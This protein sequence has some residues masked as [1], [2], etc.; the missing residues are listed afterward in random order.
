[1]RA[2]VSRP[3]CARGSTQSI[4]DRYRAGTTSRIRLN[5]SSSSIC[6]L[7][8]V[9]FNIE[10]SVTSAHSRLALVMSCATADQ[11]ESTTESAGGSQ[12]NCRQCRQTSG[13]SSACQTD[14]RSSGDLNRPEFGR[15]ATWSRGSG[16]THRPRFASSE[17]AV[18]RPPRRTA[19]I[20]STSASGVANHPLRRR[21]IAPVFTAFARARWSMPASSN[22]WTATTPPPRRTTPAASLIVSG[23]RPAT[24]LG[25]AP[26]Q[27][28]ERGGGASTVEDERTRTISG[29]PAGS[30]RPQRP[31]CRS[32]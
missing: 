24:A 18:S 30:T 7:Y 10:S 15:T 16:I 9:V 13:C 32:S 23:C 1:M 14:R 20:L 19:R 12:G 27:W 29:G 21:T 22:R 6:P 31:A 26:A 2:S 8:V 25:R 4:S 28:W 11:R 3:D 5:S 17:A